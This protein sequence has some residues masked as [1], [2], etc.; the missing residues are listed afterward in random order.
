MELLVVIERKGISGL[1]GLTV[2]LLQNLNFRSFQID[3]STRYDIFFGYTGKRT[4]LI[5]N[6]V[7][8][9]EIE[10][11]LQMFFGLNIQQSKEALNNLIQL[12]FLRVSYTNT[13]WSPRWVHNE[14]L[15][16][17]ITSNLRQ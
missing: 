2:H 7:P 11:Y 5:H 16:R 17:L 10:R 3:D 15:N 6:A 14:P 12:G 9:T 13:Q 4:Y 1:R 8:N